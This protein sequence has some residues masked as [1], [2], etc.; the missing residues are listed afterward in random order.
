M[1]SRVH[2]VVLGSFVAAWG[3]A[4]AGQSHEAEVVAADSGGGAD[5]NADAMT[6]DTSDPAAAE[7]SEA[8]MVQTT[9]TATV[10]EVQPAQPAPANAETE[11]RL[12]GEIIV[13]AR[14]TEERLQEVPIS[15]TVFDDQA[16][17]ER[18]ITN[19][20]DLG[21]A[22]P[23]LS[24][25]SYQSRSSP[26]F[27][28]RGQGD[29]YGVFQPG[30]VVYLA[31]VPDFSGFFY[32]L[33]SIQVL[34]G[35]Q[36]TLFG[37]NTTGGA[38]L[39]T[40]KKPTNEFTGY[41]VARGGTYSR[42][43]LEGGFGGPIID[44]L[45]S[46]RVAGQRLRRDGYTINLDNGED[47]DDEHRQSWRGSLTFTPFDAL[48]NYT[49]YQHDR[50]SEH[51]TGQ[52]LYAF[53]DTV[54]TPNQNELRDYL[55]IQQDRGPRRI[56][57][58]WPDY[59]EHRREGV[60]NTTTL[61][62]T[63]TVSVKNI[64]RWSKGGDFRTSIDLDGSPYRNISVMSEVEPRYVKN[65]EVQFRYDNAESGLRGVAG[66]YWE[67][68]TGGTT[69]VRAGI[70]LPGPVPVPAEVQFPDTES[71]SSG[72][73]AFIQGSWD[74]LEDWSVTLGF[75]R[76]I[77]KRS[78]EQQTDLVVGGVPVTVVAREPYDAKFRA[79]TWNIALDYQITDDLM[80]Y[81]TV[82]R[83]YKSG[84]LNVIS[85]PSQIRY[86]PEFVTDV[87]TGIKAEWSLGE[88]R[89]RSNVDL[90]Y[91]DYK[92][93]QRSVTPPTVG[94]PTLI[95]TNAAKASIWGADLE[96]LVA[97]NQVFDVAVQYSWIQTHYGEYTDPSFGDLSEGRF[98]NTPTHQIG[99]TPALHWPLPSSWGSVTAQLPFFYQSD[100]A[101]VVNNKP[102]GTPANDNAVAGSN[103][104]GF[105]RVDFRMD[106]RSIFQTPVSAALYVR[107][108]T[109]E[110]YQVG[111]LNSL[112]SNLIGV[113]NTI[114]AAPRMVA[115]EL[116][117]DF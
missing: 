35:P 41:A 77:D 46:F 61:S 6:P 92:D 78:S 14:K 49:L 34:K 104:P 31:E 110:D 68:S 97:P 76:T 45:L 62:L 69:D 21:Q 113:A 95:I 50:I 13:T 105:K 109:Q 103:Y 27:S 112:T 117:Y 3:A 70:A 48:E 108:L 88:T 52:V 24:A 96:L 94:V 19:A 84:G 28:I 37:K 25:I 7:P 39:L 54:T 36:G 65:D 115:F 100:F 90:F 26:A 83:G 79:N 11:K 101:V 116:R 1:A 80:A 93:I 114:Y 42:F 51:G 44:D 43:D 99:I 33:S 5:A 9:A 63:D 111:G 15:V 56:Q 86:E 59:F 53:L 29:V 71:A 30:V 67:K 74:F 82:R 72:K 17:S 89:I 64:F 40:P 107:N 38:V 23:G 75:R 58:D 2:G 73:A 12:F 106:W 16:L 102:N 32:D 87:E 66:V 81:A 91:D 55:P 20:N 85:D 60:V 57:H 18:N 8:P 4:F 22:S 98:P 10:S 47:L